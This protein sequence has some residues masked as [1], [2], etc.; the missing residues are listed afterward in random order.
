MYHVGDIKST[1]WCPQGLLASASSQ[2]EAPYFYQSTRMTYHNDR[3]NNTL[4]HWQNTRLWLRS[5]TTDK[6]LTEVNASCVI[7]TPN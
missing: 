7:P 5:V 6:K 4:A 1:Y 2:S 3:E